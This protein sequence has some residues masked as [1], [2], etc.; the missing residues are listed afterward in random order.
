MSISLAD[1]KFFK[2]DYLDTGKQYPIVINRHL[3]ATTFTFLSMYC[4][5]SAQLFGGGYPIITKYSQ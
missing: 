4:S 1:L 3:K 2:L 5:K